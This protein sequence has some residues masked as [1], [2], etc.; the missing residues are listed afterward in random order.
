MNILEDQPAV[1]STVTTLTFPVRPTTRLAKPYHYR[2]NG[3]YYIRLRATGCTTEAAAVSL[4][5]IGGTRW[6]LQLK[7][8]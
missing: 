3:I 6:T 1:T 7:G 5:A 8:T 4:K 2:H